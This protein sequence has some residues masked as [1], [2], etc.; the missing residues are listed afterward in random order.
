MVHN[1]ILQIQTLEN[2]TIVSLASFDINIIIIITWQVSNH[3]WPMFHKI[4]IIS[5]YKTNFICPMS[6]SVYHG[7]F[8]VLLSNCFRTAIFRIEPN[9]IYCSNSK[10]WKRKLFLILWFF[11][12]KFFFYSLCVK[13]SCKYWYKLLEKY[14]TYC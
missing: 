2:T 5:F 6:K 10:E 1:L 4:F 12:V 9:N 7:P 14:L 11:S 8:P 13:Q 3:L